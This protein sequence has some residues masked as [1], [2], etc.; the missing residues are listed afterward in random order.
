MRHRLTGKTAVR[1]A[2]KGLP[3]RM[4]T[5]GPRDPEKDRAQKQPARE[6]P[7]NAAAPAGDIWPGLV[8]GLRGKFPAV[9]PFLSNPAAVR[10][11]LED[12]V[13]TL[14]VDTEFTKNMVGA[15]AVLET[16]GQLAGAQTGRPVRCLVKVGTP[17]KSAQMSAAPAEHDNLDDL[18]AIGQQFDNIII[19]E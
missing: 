19:Q 6:Q 18:L 3:P 10:G 15:T 7:A 16:L 1:K 2:G 9:Y 11:V 5:A 13:L 14:W 12:A 8:A 4:R 17:P